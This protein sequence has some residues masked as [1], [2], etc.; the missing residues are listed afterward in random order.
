MNEGTRNKSNST[1]LIPDDSN[2]RLK[3]SAYVSS[4]RGWNYSRIGVVVKRIGPWSYRHWRSRAQDRIAKRKS[5]VP[6]R[7][8]KRR[9]E[10]DRLSTSCGCSWIHR[11]TRASKIHGTANGRETGWSRESFKQA[12]MSES[13]MGEGKPACPL[14]SSHLNSS[15]IL[16]QNLRRHESSKLGDRIV[17]L[18]D[19]ARR[20]CGA[21]RL[22]SRG[23][24]R[25]RVKVSG[26]KFGLY[27]C[28]VCSHSHGC[29]RFPSLREICIEQWA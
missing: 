7:F 26:A 5:Q 18:H 27:T 16:P 17:R 22:H 8:P 4:S 14:K 12:R 3:R 20:E 10:L 9:K 13:E 21:S 29:P 25:R 1:S 28:Q 2:T 23:F 19:R 24:L 11:M 15:Q 6:N